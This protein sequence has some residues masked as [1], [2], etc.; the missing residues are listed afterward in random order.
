MTKRAAFTAEG[1]TLD[2]AVGSIPMATDASL[3]GV[4]QQR[5][6][7][8]DPNQQ[9]AGNTQGIDDPRVNMGALSHVG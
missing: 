5:G 3:G 9:H 4:H 1:V 7:Y 8:P 6:Q 2:K